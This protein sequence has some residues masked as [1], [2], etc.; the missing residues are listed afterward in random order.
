[1]LGALRNIT[2]GRVRTKMKNRIFFFF[3]AHAKNPPAQA[4]LNNMTSGAVGKKKHSSA[5]VDLDRRG[6]SIFKQATIVGVPIFHT[7]LSA[8]VTDWTNSAR[9]KWH[10]DSTHAAVSFQPINCVAPCIGSKPEICR[11]KAQVHLV[12]SLLPPIKRA[13]IA[14][15]IAELSQS[16]NQSSSVM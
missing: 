3:F 4:V 16:R 12:E 1:M 8:S 2:M 11:A 9:Q 14:V 13:W 10:R 15:V 5:R 7:L 6:K